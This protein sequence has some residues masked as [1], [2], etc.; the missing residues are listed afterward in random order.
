VVVERDCDGTNSRGP[1]HITPGRAES[2]SGVWSDIHDAAPADDVMANCRRTSAS[3]VCRS[4]GDDAR[5]GRRTLLEAA[6]L[7]VTRSS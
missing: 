1:L 4:A 2:S 7:A 5:R 3:A 6:R